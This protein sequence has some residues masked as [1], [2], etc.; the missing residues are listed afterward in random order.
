MPLAGTPVRDQTWWTEFGGELQKRE[1]A[2]CLGTGESD[3]LVKRIVE[4]VA[5]PSIQAF[6]LRYGFFPRTGYLDL[7]PRFVLKSVAPVLKPGIVQYSGPADV[8]GY[9]TAYYHAA[10]RKGGGV[11]LQLLSA[12]RLMDRTVT[13]V[14]SPATIRLDLPETARY[15]RYFFR[16]WRVAGDRKIALLATSRKD[17]LDSLTRRFESDPEG[18]CRTVSP[19]E[20]SCIAI[21]REAVVTPETVLRLNGKSSSVIIAGTVGDAARA[22]G[23]K[24]QEDLLS[25]IQ[26]SRPYE[27][28]LLPVEFDRSRSDVLRL[29]L[30]GGEE[31]RW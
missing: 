17:T 3:L 29:V 10:G 31:V 9:E 16:E 2:G 6:H 15:V 26:V 27:G 24:K 13:K 5:M 12:E 21:P 1:E 23:V 28:R 18:F 11:K 7:E 30:I 4:N 19:A 8:A 14:K 25:T 22:A 20:A